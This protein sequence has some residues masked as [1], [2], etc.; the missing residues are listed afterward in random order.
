MTFAPPAPDEIEEAPS[1]FVPPSPDDIETTNAPAAPSA[2]QFAPPPA[3]PATP[4]PTST[5]ATGAFTRQAAEN[6]LPAYGALA[7]AKVAGSPVVKK[8]A[9]GAVGRFLGGLGLGEAIG[10]GPEDPLADVLGVGLGLVGAIIGSTVAD[11]AQHEA[12]KVAAPQVADELEQFQQEDLKDHPVAS[13]AGSLFGSL[14][15]FKLANPIQ[16]ATAANAI[17]KIA[18]GQ[19]VTAIEKR[20]ATNLA[21]Q[22][23]L[24]AGM[25]VVNPL[26]QG[27]KPTG[28]EITQSVAQ[29][30]L[31][32]EPRKF[33]KSSP[34]GGGGTTTGDQN[35]LDQPETTGLPVRNEGEGVGETAP[36]RQQGEAAPIPSPNAAC[37]CAARRSRLD[38][39]RHRARGR[40]D[41]GTVCRRI[42]AGAGQARRQTYCASNIA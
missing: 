28:G 31:F 30:L 2:Y 39:R 40:D 4:A 36:L 16:T 6:I 1:S 7:G 42:P 32:G 26:L 24:G 38:L 10:L 25:G 5:T 35:A 9:T 13:F 12:L 17:R 14:P 15:A 18:A 11:K 29:F 20:L 19:P 27:Q 33:G 37:R 3:A 21:V 8:A 23:G 22:A 41:A 34:P